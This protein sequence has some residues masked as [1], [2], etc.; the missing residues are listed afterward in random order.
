[1]LAVVGGGGNAVIIW[2]NSVLTLLSMP[3]LTYIGPATNGVYL[4]WNGAG[5]VTPSAIRQ[6]TGGCYIASPSTANSP[7]PTSNCTV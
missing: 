7:Y 4:F 6:Y 2:S 5:L 3:A 1:M